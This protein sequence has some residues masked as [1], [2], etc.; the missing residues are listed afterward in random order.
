MFPAAF[1]RNQKFLWFR[2]GTKI[3]RDER[4]L[5]FISRIYAALP[6]R[7]GLKKG[8]G[9]KGNRDYGAAFICQRWD[10]SALR[11]RCRRLHLCGRRRVFLPS[12]EDTSLRRIWAPA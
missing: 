10:R 12:R 8:L 2:L 6:A 3:A 9:L 4:A 1:C 11:A 7:R 5:F